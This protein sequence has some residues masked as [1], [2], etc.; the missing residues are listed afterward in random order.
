MKPTIQILAQTPKIST[1]TAHDFKQNRE[2]PQH[3]RD[4][5]REISLQSRDVIQLP[6]DA[7]QQMRDSGQLRDS[8]HYSRELMQQSR[9][10]TQQQRDVTQQSRD[11]TQQSRDVPQQSRDVTQQPRDVTQ[12]SRDVTQHSRD[13]TQQSRDTTQHSRDSSLSREVSHSKEGVPTQ[14]S[15]KADSERKTESGEGKQSIVTSSKLNTTA[16]TICV[17]AISKPPTSQSKQPYLPYSSKVRLVVR[18]IYI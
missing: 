15:G 17:R 1:I 12:Q 4:P 2:L 5:A 7:T 9:D 13:V 11:V 16:P 10:V 14:S 8:T 18:N 6:R 3:M